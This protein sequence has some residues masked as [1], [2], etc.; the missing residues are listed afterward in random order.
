MI[1]GEMNLAS[2]DIFKQEILKDLTFELIKIILKPK[3]IRTT[4]VMSLAQQY[5]SEFIH[6]DKIEITEELVNKI[7]IVSKSVK[8]YFSYIL[9]DFAL[10][11]PSLEDLPMGVAFQLAENLGLKDCFNDAV[12]KELKLT[13]RKLLDL[14]NKTTK[15]LAEVKESKDEHIYNE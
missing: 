12:K 6:N 10:V 4:E 7:G 3:W 8:E 2:L 15:A 14:Q 11:D 9:L 5:Q 13:S 1:E